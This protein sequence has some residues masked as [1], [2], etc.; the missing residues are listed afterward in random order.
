MKLFKEFIEQLALQLNKPLPGE[1]AQL[2]MGSDIRMKEFKFMP[3]SE[4]T[5]KS[6]VMILL[7]PHDNTIYSVLILR[8][9]Y[10][11]THSGQVAFPGGKYEETDGDL[12]TTALRETSEEIG[13]D[14][15]KVNVLGKLTRLYIPPS[16]FEV[17]PLLGYVNK[18][19]FFKPDPK[20][21]KEI[22]EYPLSILLKA[23]TI[24]NKEFN[25]RDN[26][27]FT[28]PYFDIYGNV[29]WGATAMMLSEFREI[30]RRIDLIY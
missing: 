15:S 18:R 21:V 29:V 27:T 6:G 12:E 23:K 19:P 28:A 16:N 26:I 4:S 9:T 10:N 2:L 17:F 5:R 13:I 3:M 22:I 24:K 14:I 30:L 1:K 25:V 8:P 20:E 7:Y 11:G